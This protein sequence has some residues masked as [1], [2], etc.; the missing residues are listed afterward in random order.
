MQDRL[1]PAPVVEEASRRSGQETSI[2][3][4]T[5]QSQFSAHLRE[6]L[7][8]RGHLIGERPHSRL[9]GD[10]GRKTIFRW[11]DG[12]FTGLA[13]SSRSPDYHGPGRGSGNSL[14][15]L[16]D[17]FRLS[18]DRKYLAKAEQLMQRCVHP[19]QD[20]APLTLLDA[21][22]RWFYT[23]FLQALGRY[24]DLKVELGELDEHY[25]YGRETLLHFARWMAEHEYPF[26]E[27][28][29]ILEYPT[30]T[31]PAQ[32]MRKSE[33]FKFAALHTAG[34][35]RARFEERADYFFD[36]CVRVLGDDP[37][38]SLA[39]PVVLLLPHGW[40]HGW[41]K[42]HRT[43]E[44]P[45]P[46]IVPDGWP[47]HQAFVPQKARAMRRAK[48]IVAVGAALFAVAA[49]IAMSTLIG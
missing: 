23:M 47:V 1:D 38:R 20:I 45:Q 18:G 14:A 9:Q 34:D 37:R 33:I 44:R 21:E 30:E 5:H 4:A 43:A 27:K 24:L 13:S 31:W 41:F 3:R 39:R 36:Y 15:A 6:C 8:Q 49:V 28:P 48:A 32:D 10:D 19:E 7:L 35:E 12:G 40:M 16:V 17:G 11:L 26:L 29:E 2:G 46:Q 25:A 22:N 42:A